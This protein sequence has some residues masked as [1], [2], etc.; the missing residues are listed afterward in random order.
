MGTWEKVKDMEEK[1]EAL[2]KE[3]FKNAG[4][5]ELAKLK[6]ASNEALDKIQ[7]SVEK[8]QF[9]VHKIQTSINQLRDKFK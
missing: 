6:H 5:Q 2:K 9:G 3:D 1:F 4:A 7:D 8:A